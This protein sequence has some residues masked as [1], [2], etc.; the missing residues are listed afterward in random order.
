MKLNATEQKVFTALVRSSD[1]NGHD[2]GLLQDL[3]G[4]W[5]KVDGL[6]AK[7]VGAYVTDLQDKGLIRVHGPVTGLDHGHTVTQFV[8][9]D[10]GFRLAGL[11]DH[12]GM[13]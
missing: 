7:Q 10:E 5:G 1:G 2:F 6:T 4:V 11:T 9:T 12:V 3:T 8:L 13:H